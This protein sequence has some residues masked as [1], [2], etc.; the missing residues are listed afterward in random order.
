MFQL[1][2]DEEEAVEAS[3]EDSSESGSESAC[4]VFSTILELSAGACD[5]F[6]NQWMG[7]SSMGHR[8]LDTQGD[9][10]KSEVRMVTIKITGSAQI[11]APC[12]SQLATLGP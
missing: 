2:P 9:I 12:S 4:L 7:G 5:G 8:I 6:K 1:G 11:G 3:S 10:K